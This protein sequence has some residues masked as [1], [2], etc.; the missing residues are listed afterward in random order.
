MTNDLLI[1]TEG[2]ENAVVAL[3]V[4][5]TEHEIHEPTIVAP[6][7]A[8]PRPSRSHRR[9]WRD[10]HPASKR[11]LS[12]I[13][14]LLFV[15][16]VLG[17]ALLIA[18]PHALVEGARD[19]RPVTSTSDDPSVDVEEPDD[20]AV[21]DADPT[22]AQPVRRAHDG[23]VAQSTGGAADGSSATEQ[24]AAAPTTAPATVATAPPTT[25]P[26]VTTPTTDPPVAVT[27]TAPPATPPSTEPAPGPPTTAPPAD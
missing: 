10:V 18:R 16:C 22:V 17:G 14:T 8:V 7:F 23:T 21:V 2:T 20:R 9:R 15:D 26:P 12:V 19:Q 3:D 5:I 24:A 4:D 1:R 6:S 13:V 11:R 25:D 27:T